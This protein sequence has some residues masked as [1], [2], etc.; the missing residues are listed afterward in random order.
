MIGLHYWN[1]HGNVPVRFPHLHYG[2]VITLEA[3]TASIGAGLPYL[4]YI[5][6]RVEVQ[7]VNLDNVIDNHKHV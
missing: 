6:L 2:C 7:L 3:T 4:P 1:C 5:V